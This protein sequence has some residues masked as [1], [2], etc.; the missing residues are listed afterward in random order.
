MA[1]REG[2][3]VV[4]SKFS[5]IAYFKNKSGKLCQAP[6]NTEGSIDFREASMVDYFFLT[7]EELEEAFMAL[8]IMEE[9]DEIQ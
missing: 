4:I 3:N 8:E 6:V 1:F 9:Q 7:T 5:N 2:Q